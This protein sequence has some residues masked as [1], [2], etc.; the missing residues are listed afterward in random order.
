MQAWRF[1]NLCLVNIVAPESSRLSSVWLVMPSPSRRDAASSAAARPVDRRYAGSLRGSVAPR[2]SECAAG[3][4][5]SN[6]GQWMPS[7]AQ[8]A[9]VGDRVAFLRHRKLEL[10][11][12][13]GAKASRQLRALWDHPI[14]LSRLREARARL[15]YIRYSTSDEDATVR[16]GDG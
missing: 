13:P 12:K 16:Q 3:Q 6:E 11:G 5:R 7:E 15:A 14:Q 8:A 10:Y 2:R 4:L 9:V 1:T